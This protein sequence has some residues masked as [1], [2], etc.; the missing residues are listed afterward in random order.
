MY[1]YIAYICTYI[2]LA[3]SLPMI[4]DNLEYTNRLKDK[5]IS[6]WTIILQAI[7]STYVRIYVHVCIHM[8]PIIKKNL[9]RM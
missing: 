8:V 2:S 6:Y 1:I 9:G 7:K 5:K 3:Y 4:V